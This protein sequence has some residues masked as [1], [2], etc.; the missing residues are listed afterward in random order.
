MTHLKGHLMQTNLK[1]TLIVIPAFNEEDVIADVLKEVFDTNPGVTCLVVDDGSHDRTSEIARAS[2]ALVATLPYNLGVG[3]AMR[4]GF[5]YALANGFENVVQVDGDGQHNP[6]DVARLVAK[7]SHA[8]LVLGARFA[9]SGNYEAKGPRKWAMVVLAKLLSRSA[10]SQLT[11]TTSG[12]RASGPR[13]VSLFAEHYPAEYLGDTVESLVIAACAGYTI[14]QVPV[15]MRER[16]G[17][18]PSHS[19]IKATVFLVRVGVAMLFA[20][21]R[22]PVIPSQRSQA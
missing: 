4:V 19:P 14:E 21:L 10:G 18:A 1:R 20:F 15:S 7:L 17:G 13:A 5:N 6:R 8:D 12:F 22:P 16:A 2:G 3:G 11:D 9:G